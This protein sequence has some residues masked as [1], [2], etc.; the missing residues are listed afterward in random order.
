MTMENVIGGIGI[1]SIFILMP[2]V[3]FLIARLGREDNYD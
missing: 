3:M 1:I 2:I